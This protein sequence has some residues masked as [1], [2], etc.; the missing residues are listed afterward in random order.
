MSF[1]NDSENVEKYIEMCKDYEGSNI[2]Q[3]L[4]KHLNDGKTILELGSGPGFDIPFLN[5][6]YQVTGSDLSDEFLRRC[7]NK[8]PAISFLKLDAADIDVREQF[9]CIYSNKVL[10][11]LTQDELALSLLQ[12]KKALSTNGI[13]AHSFWIGDE[14]QEMEGLLFTYYRKEQLIEIISEHFE[15][16]STMDY[17]E[18]EESDSL[19]V[20][21]QLKVQG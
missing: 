3:S 14:S 6:H 9:D 5:E 19:F 12:Q 13:I 4:K 10:H 2:Y 18:F 16:L 11:H 7:K 15:I 20:I 17:Q 21:A 8:F 1:Y